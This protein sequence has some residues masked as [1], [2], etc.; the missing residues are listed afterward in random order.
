MT[1]RDDLRPPTPDELQRQAWTWLRRLSS[2]DVT[3]WDADAFKRWLRTSPAH[4]A[5][6]SDA[7]REW[8]AVRP[9]AGA[10]LHSN[11]EASREHIRALQGPKPNVGRRAFLGAAVSAAGVAGIAIFHPPAGLWPAPSEWGADFR[12]ATGEQRA[13][14]VASTVSVTL[15]TETSIRRETSGG[16]TVGIRLLSGE[17]AVDVTA[18][19]NPFV[20]VSG[21]GRSLASVGRLEVRRMDGSTCVTCIDGAVNVEHPSGRVALRTGEQTVYDD[22]TV[23]RVRRVAV[24]DVS[25]WRQGMLVFR[26]TPLNQVIEEI[27]RYRR[28]RV[29][30]MNA[31]MGHQPVSGSFEIPLLDMAVAQLQRTFD[32]NARTLP[33]GL[34]VL[35]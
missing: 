31:A 6:F 32:L 12:T 23:G 19:R 14:Q 11:P 34:I 2:G 1:A 28:G 22:A 20:V 16:A 18:S 29:V 30:L 15:N 9:A 17:A 10:V 13:I 33:G 21:V 4:H 25:A 7:K 8:A 26:Q 27:N 5:A 24:A 3:S 35:S